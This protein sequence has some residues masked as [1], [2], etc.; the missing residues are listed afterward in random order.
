VLKPEKVENHCKPATYFLN[1]PL[2]T[3]LVG[4]IKELVGVAVDEED[5]YHSKCSNRLFSS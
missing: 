3:Y 5:Y 2:M 4:K 1:G